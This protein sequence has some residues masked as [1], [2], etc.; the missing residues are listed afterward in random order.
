M[1][2]LVAH[3]LRRD[4]RGRCG[5][6]VAQLVVGA[7]GIEGVAPDC[8][9]RNDLLD[10]PEG[11]GRQGVV[12]DLDDDLSA[13]RV[14]RRRERC[15]VFEHERPPFDISPVARFRNR[16]ER[17][18]ERVVLVIVV[19]GT[20]RPGDDEDADENDGSGERQQ[21]DSLSHV[22]SPVDVQLRYPRSVEPPPRAALTSTK[23]YIIFL[24]ICQD[25]KCI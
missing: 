15:A 25:I 19:R 20:E 1:L 23:E 5:F 4:P 21:E 22:K 14:G 24:G 2:P 11:A 18:L 9:R 6:L 16:G 12:L 17:M 8:Q 13:V 10:D 7:A 3:V